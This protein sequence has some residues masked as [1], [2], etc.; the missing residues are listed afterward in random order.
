M[1][2]PFF[3]TIYYYSSHAMRKT[4]F[5]Y[6]FKNII[7]WIRDEQFEYEIIRWINQNTQ[8]MLGD[9]NGIIFG[10]FS[11]KWSVSASDNC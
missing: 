11:V 9:E 7:Y 6:K 8:D 5:L 3:H 1:W 4:H 10:I 2:K